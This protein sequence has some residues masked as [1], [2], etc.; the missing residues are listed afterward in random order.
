MPKF[1][2]VPSSAAAAGAVGLVAGVAPAGAGVFSGAG[3]SARML[4]LPEDSRLRS[5]LGESRTTSR[6]RTVCENSGR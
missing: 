6:S 2:G 3:T 4:K 1:Q 5:T